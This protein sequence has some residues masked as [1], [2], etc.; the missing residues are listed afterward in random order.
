MVAIVHFSTISFFICYFFCHLQIFIWCLQSHQVF[1][2]FLL[3]FSSYFRDSR[4]FDS[5]LRSIQIKSWLESIRF[6]FN[7][8]LIQFL[9]V[10]FQINSIPFSNL[11]HKSM[12][13][14]SVSMQ[15]E[16]VSF[17]FNFIIMHFYEYVR[18]V[19][20][21][22]LMSNYKLIK[23]NELPFM[24]HELCWVKY[25]Q[26]YFNSFQAMVTLISKWLPK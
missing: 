10:I 18:I 21:L 3:K 16:L 15:F 19:L 6:T 4:G 26:T 7:L 5:L 23:T 14:S 17:R 22:T 13:L 8:V 2:F 24:L 25:E 11:V 12:K 9:L 1:F 20:R